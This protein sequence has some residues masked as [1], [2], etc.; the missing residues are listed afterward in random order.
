MKVYTK[1]FLLAEMSKAGVDRIII[2]P[3]SWEGDR[4]DLALAAAQAHP[5]RF[6]V[7]GRPISMHRMPASRSAAG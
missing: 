4:N 6:A 7:M 2:V 1:D 5:E 3:P